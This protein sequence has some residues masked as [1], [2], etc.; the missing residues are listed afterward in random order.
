M[1]LHA[2]MSSVGTVLLSNISLEP[3]VRRGGGFLNKVLHFFYIIS[4]F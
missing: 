1:L 4:Q 3:L 2:I